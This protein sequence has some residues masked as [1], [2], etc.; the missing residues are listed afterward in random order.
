MAKRPTLQGFD[1]TKFVADPRACILPKGATFGDRRYRYK[2]WWCLSTDEK[3]QVAQRYPH[4]TP[5]IPDSAYAYPIDAHGRL[6]QGRASRTL[7]WSRKHV[8]S[9]VN[10]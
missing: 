4:N 9:K 10:R 7:I 3:R 8:I 2:N 1:K 5:G 6:P